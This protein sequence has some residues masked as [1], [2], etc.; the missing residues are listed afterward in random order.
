MNKHQKNVKS[1]QRRW[2]RE[3]KDHTWLTISAIGDSP[4][5]I[6]DLVN[7]FLKFELSFGGGLYFMEKERDPAYIKRAE[8]VKKDIDYLLNGDFIIQ[9]GDKYSVTNKGTEVVE[10]FAEKWKFVNKVVNKVLSVKV[11]PLASLV[12]HFILGILKL[13][14]F[15]LTGSVGLLGDGI[16]SSIDGISSIVV[17]IA[18]RHKKEKYA[19]YFLLLLMLASGILVMYES[20]L[21]IVE[22]LTIEITQEADIFGIIV[23]SVSI[24][25]CLLLY[26][27]Q[28]LVGYTR[29]SLV[30][31]VQSED[32]R[33]HILVGLLVLI[34]IIA[35]MYDI[36]IIDGIIGVFIGGLILWSCY[37]VF[38]D[39]RAVDK[40][41]NINY[42][43]YKLGMW[44]RLDRFRSS[45]LGI[46]ILYMVE[47]G[48][49]TFESLEEQFISLFHPRFLKFLEI[50]LKQ[51]EKEEEQQSKTLKFY[52]EKEELHNQ[53]SKLIERKFIEE[54]QGTLVITAMGKSE[55]KKQEEKY[56][57]KYQHH[58]KRTRKR[59]K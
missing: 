36:F 30:I 19:S 9:E 40:G 15:A 20:I 37:Q 22:A 1:N 49:D 39:L 47:K 5:T 46:W 12:V 48:T 52:Y 32:S 34:G 14:G 57:K 27:Y 55:L 54:V 33:N 53:F 24:F 3:I 58:I 21:Q 59:L 26:V 35:G 45:K 56:V 28:R 31:V 17:S 6:E 8:V 25:L 43:K 2:D 29:K 23:A 4:C 13:T 51:E 16:D 18:M 38:K 7:E 11:P 42:E 44:K 50:E 41:E 10:F